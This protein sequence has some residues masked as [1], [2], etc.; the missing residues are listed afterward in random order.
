MKTVLIIE[1][2]PHLYSQLSEELNEYLSVLDINLLSSNDLDSGLLSTVDSLVI[3]IESVNDLKSFS[4]LV[5]SSNIAQTILLTETI[6]NKKVRLATTLGFET[7]YCHAPYTTLIEKIV[8]DY[9]VQLQKAKMKHEEAVSPNQQWTCCVYSPSGGVGKSTIAVNIAAQF[10][11]AGKSVLLVDFAQIG[12]IQALCH[13]PKQT[14][15]LSRILDEIQIIE[16]DEYDSNINNIFESNTYQVEGDSCSIDVMFSA[17]L[18][19]MEKIKEHDVRLFHEIALSMGYDV[20]VYDTSSEMCER[21]ISV[22]D[23]VDR[24]LL[25]TVPSLTSAMRLLETKEILKTIG[26]FTKTSFVMNQHSKHAGFLAEELELEIQCP[27]TGV[28]K[29]RPVLRHWS[30]ENIPISLSSKNKYE[31]AYKEIALKLRPEFEIN[32]EEKS[33]KTKFSFRR[34]S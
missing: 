23:L 4:E 18:L 1:K 30:N 3:S 2:E 25:I 19:K 8:T 28:V 15:G 31:R 9:R 17:S 24:V 22:L 21:N 10:S 29:D 5:K 26:C 27:L 11:K 32:E 6:S 13:V 20:I 16:N 7:H 34:S 14:M 33:K 12:S